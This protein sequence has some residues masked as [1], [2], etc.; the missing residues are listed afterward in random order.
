LREITT[1]E[2]M[3]PHEE[4]Q[5]DHDSQPE[6]VMIWS[7]DNF[8]KVLSLKLR[9][10]ERLDPDLTQKLPIFR[11]DLK[12]ITI[13]QPHSRVLTNQDT[14]VVHVSNYAACFVDHAKRPCGV[15]RRSKQKTPIG[16][17]EEGAPALRT[18]KVMDVRSINDPWHY[19]PNRFTRPASKDALRPCGQLFKSR[20]AHGD[21]QPNFFDLLF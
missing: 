19:K 15:C 9:R 7:S 3:T 5:K 4:H 6:V 10:R 16:S 13:N 1:G 2:W 18:V 8:L 20:I 14:A 12:A 11:N 21:H 17:H